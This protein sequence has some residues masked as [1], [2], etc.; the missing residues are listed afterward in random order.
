MKR[1]VVLNCIMGGC[2]S[3]LA[4]SALAQAQILSQNDGNELPVVPP[5]HTEVPVVP[6]NH[7]EIPVVPPNHNFDLPVV[8]PNHRDVP[9]VPPQNKPYLKFTETCIGDYVD[10]PVADL[11][12]GTGNPT[13]KPLAG[14]DPL[15]PRWE[16]QGTENGLTYSDKCISVNLPFIGRLP[17]PI[18][19]WR[20][21]VGQPEGYACR[22]WMDGEECKRS[23]ELLRPK[24][25]GNVVL[26]PRALG[27]KTFGG[28][29]PGDAQFECDYKYGVREAGEN[30]FI[31]W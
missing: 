2:I 30:F 29:R 12:C 3:A 27:G 14:A 11:S 20:Q 23:I 28:A 18:C 26:I 4:F 22:L 8:P 25:K 16:Q 1:R 21:Q 9:P 15:Y 17:L 19:K 31:I 7:S 13:A 5:N 6:P 24:C 10:D